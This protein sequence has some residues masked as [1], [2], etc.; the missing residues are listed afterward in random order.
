[1]NMRRLYYLDKNAERLPCK[2][3]VKCQK[4]RFF[5]LFIKGEDFSFNLFLSRLMWCV[6][7]HGKA[8]IFYVEQEGEILH[9]SLVIPSCRKFPFLNKCDYEIGP[10]FTDE[11]ARG[12]GYYPQ[13]L[14]FIIK[15]LK[16]AQDFYMIVDDEN[17]ASIKGI[18]KAGFIETGYCIARSRFGKHK[19]VKIS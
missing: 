19:K 1:M 17:I 12:R 4:I 18:K 8:R 7:A 6:T 10:C 15:N 3:S 5:S 16:N 13:T 11:S 9:T 14:D 2:V